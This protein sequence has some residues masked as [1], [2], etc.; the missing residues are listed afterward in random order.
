MSNDIDSLS[1]HV[2]C[3]INPIKSYPNNATST[4][5][6]FQNICDLNTRRQRCKNRLER[7]IKNTAY[8]QPLTKANSK[9]LITDGPTDKESDERVLLLINSIDADLMQC[10]GRQQFWCNRKRK[11]RTPSR[12]RKR[13]RY[14]TMVNSTIHRPIVQE[15]CES[16]G[17]R[18][19]L[20]VLTSLWFPWT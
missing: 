2:K 18:P 6:F 4:F 5:I 19:G 7:S 10:M 14:N 1:N 17:G 11:T 12:K 13:T 20:S 8:K 15:L 3:K 16:R 9:G